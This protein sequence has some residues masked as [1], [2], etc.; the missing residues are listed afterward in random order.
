MNTLIENVLQWGNDKGITGP[1]G[2]GTIQKQFRKFVEEMAELFAAL[3]NGDV[4]ETRDA[5]GDLQVV[6]VQANSLIDG[7]NTLP[8]D[9]R[10]DRQTAH[11]DIETLAGI[12]MIAILTDPSAAFTGIRQISRR[13]GHDPDE[14]LQEAYDEIKGRTGQMVD[15]VFIKES[16]SID[17]DLGELDPS[18]A[19]KLGDE[20]C[21]SCQ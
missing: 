12:S 16:P 10:P 8:V 2:K 1:N 3:E 4:K 19:C 11:K 21:E 9:H 14:C 6:A 7:I 18:A 13:L 15:G 17:D 5:L 20:S